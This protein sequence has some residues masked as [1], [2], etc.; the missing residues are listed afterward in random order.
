MDH[1]GKHLTHSLRSF[2]PTFAALKEKKNLSVTTD[3]PM[4]ESAQ[5]SAAVKQC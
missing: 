1:M 4:A 3:V 2:K 5:C